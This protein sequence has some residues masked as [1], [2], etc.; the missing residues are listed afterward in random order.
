M[1]TLQTYFCWLFLRKLGSHRKN[2]M[3]CIKH[4]SVILNCFH[5]NTKTLKLYNKIKKR[6]FLKIVC[7]RG[8]HVFAWTFVCATYMCVCVML[9][10]AK[11]N[12]IGYPSTVVTGISCHVGAGIEPQSSGRE[13]RAF[14]LWVIS[15]TSNNTFNDTIR[16]EHNTQSTKVAINGL[17][18]FKCKHFL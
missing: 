9:T 13:A 17:N 8:I 5:L 18:E 16:K 4:I 6:I 3:L 14:N 1:G 11:E 2:L 7:A 10:E 12:S 15:P